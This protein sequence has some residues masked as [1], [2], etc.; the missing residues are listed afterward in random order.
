[1]RVCQLRQL[2]ITIPRI[3]L[4]LSDASRKTP[5]GTEGYIRLSS[6]QASIQRVNFKPL[7][8]KELM[9]KLKSRLRDRPFMVG[10]RGEGFPEYLAEPRGSLPNAVFVHNPCQA[11]LAELV[12]KCMEYVEENLTDNPAILFRNLPAQTAQDFSTI[13]KALPWQRLEFKGGPNYRNKVDKDAGTYTANDDPSQI[14]I[15]PHNELSYTDAYPS[16]IFFFCVQEP[17][18]GCG[19]ETPLVRNSELLAKL[20][21]DVV[22]KF[23]EKQVRYVRYL[24]DKS[25]GEYLNWQHVYQTDNREAVEAQ[26]KKQGSNITWNPSGDLYV[27]QNRPASINHPITGQKTWFNQVITSN[28]TYFRLLP[29]FD[30]IPDNKLPSNTYYGDGSAIEPAVLQHIV[31]RKWSCAVGFKWKKGDLLVLDNLAVQHGRVGFKGDRQI[32]ACMTV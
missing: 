7:P 16:K 21:P 22:R 1:M 26:A 31:A 23:D 2:R 24:P 14:S 11:S 29:K 15:A 19:G 12:A 18:E 32:L 10:S 30:G 6:T 25:N 17:G 27:W 5:F 13:A 9:P 8:I 20:D 28:A 3:A 4:F